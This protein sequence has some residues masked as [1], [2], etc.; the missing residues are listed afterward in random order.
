MSRR[1]KTK[2]WLA[3]H[4][5]DPFVRRAREEGKRSRAAFKL[6]EILDRFSIRLRKG[7]VAIDLG[8]APGA[9]SEELARRLGK[10]GLVIAIDR[11]PMQPIAGVHF[12]QGDFTTP[13][14][15]QAVERLLAGR[16]ANVVVSDAAPDLCGIAFVDQARS[17]ELAKAAFALARC[18][19]AERG[20]FVVKTFRG[21]GWQQLRTELAA[22]FDE[23]RAFKPAA[24]R[25]QSAEIYLVGLGFRRAGLNGD[26]QGAE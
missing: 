13:E 10:A 6:S 8:A 11:L 26:C 12:V 25:A 20:A 23:L 1:K 7:G 24:S 18:W 17:I 15:Q 5:S 3:R 19:L 14:V 16:K 4:R 21:E 22:A 2:A 9:W